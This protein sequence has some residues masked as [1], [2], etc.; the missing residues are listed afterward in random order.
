MFMHFRTRNIAGVLAFVLAGAIAAG[1][2]AFTASNLRRL[3]PQG[4]S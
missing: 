3:A 4:L 2:Y 1:A